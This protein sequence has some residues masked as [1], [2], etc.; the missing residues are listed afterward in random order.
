MKSGYNI[1]WTR[2]GP[3]DRK[4]RVH[5]VEESL[6]NGLTTKHFWSLVDLLDQ[7]E[8]KGHLDP[9]ILEEL[10]ST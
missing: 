2:I 3:T 6:E 4:T 8:L 1:C 5:K 9:F 10:E 7:N